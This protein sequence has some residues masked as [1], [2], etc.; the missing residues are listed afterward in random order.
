M[1]KPK[2]DELGLKLE[3]AVMD[4]LEQVTG[5]EIDPELKLKV[6]DRAL[7]YYAVKNKIGDGSLGAG[8]RDD[9]DKE[10]E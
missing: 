9:D 2:K 1:A 4:M 10:N 6:F 7:K 3:K 5:G 8:F